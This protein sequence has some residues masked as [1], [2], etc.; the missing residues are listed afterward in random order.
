MTRQDAIQQILAIV[1]GAR[2]P[3]APVIVETSPIPRVRVSARPPAFS[4][5]QPA[6]SQAG[7]AADQFT[8]EKTAAAN[9]E[10]EAEQLHRE[11]EVKRAALNGE[12]A[13]LPMTDLGN[14]ER[15][16]KRFGD[17]FKWT[18]ALGWLYWDGRRWAR[19]GADERVRI[20]AHETVRAIQDEAKALFGEA[21][22]I[23]A[24]FAAEELEQAEQETTPKK[25]GGK[26]PA[27]TLVNDRDN[28]DRAKNGKRGRKKKSAA[29]P[30]PLERK[31]IERFLKFKRLRGLA[32]ALS[33]WGLDSEMNSK[34]VPIDKHAAPY[35]AVDV[36]AFDADPWMFNCHNGTLV[37]DRDA[38][39]MIRF[40][41][42]DPADLISK[43]S[44][45][46][47]DPRALCPLFD[48]FIER[49]QPEPAQRRLLFAWLGYSLTGDTAEQKLMMLHG[50]GRNGKGVFVRICSH[51]AGDYA[52]ATPIETFLAETAARNASQPTPH[53][54]ALPGVRMLTTNEPRKGAVL[55]EAFIKLVTGDDMLPAREL[56]KPQFEFKPAFKL[57]I[58]GNHKPKIHDQTES[59]W[60]RMM[61]VP[62]DVIIPKPERDLKLDGKLMREAA[63][64]LNV[65]L[66]GLRDW[67]VN[68]IVLSDATEKATA[69]YREASDP[70]G[71]FLTDCVLA[72]KGA[73]VQSTA[74]HEL[75][76]A[77]ARATGG[78][79]WKHTG[80]TNAMIDRGFETK[81]S[82]V[83]FFL[84][85]RAVKKVGDF[86]DHLGRALAGTEDD[87]GKPAARSV[88]VGDDDEITF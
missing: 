6:P 73:R 15:F 56:N 52:K 66:D 38:P 22:A 33:E 67:L 62:W 29:E 28:P 11:Q 3:V 88:D 64:V 53:L 46:D 14:V 39:G 26:G 19:K 40:K 76:V 37:V 20:A 7:E 85:I 59:I 1:A 9:A 69:K 12:L 58:S 35:L 82:N 10:A 61:L 44:P 50:E 16:R 43:L 36:E 86:V 17:A 78:P 68:G 63:G 13:H 48:R 47:Y 34:I 81:K 72:E 55:D 80:F 51:I 84:D 41:P 70:L 79:E 74:L 77:W 4:P 18:A 23:Q 75:F 83:M 32:M 42:H 49:V 60:S 57:T 21:D 24:E 5:Q 31:K 8:P 27:L 45:V 2:A 87:R 30:A 71:R 65:L 25:K 54:A